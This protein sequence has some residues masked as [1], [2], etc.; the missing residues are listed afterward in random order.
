MTRMG[1]RT[2]SWARAQAQAIKAVRFEAEFA[3]TRTLSQ[4]STLLAQETLSTKCSCRSLSSSTFF[5]LPPP[6]SQLHHPHRHRHVASLTHPW[7][8]YI[9]TLHLRVCKVWPSSNRTGRID[10]N[11]L[12]LVPLPTTC[13]ITVLQR[14]FSESSLLKFI[15]RPTQT[16]TISSI[17]LYKTSKI[18]A[19]KP[20]T[21]HTCKKRTTLAH[22]RRSYPH[23]PPFYRSA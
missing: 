14:G 4:S 8:A 10:Q 3:Q 1:E 12:S 5:R 18:S 11:P 13:S 7:Q 16:L 19:Q 17:S 2:W 21:G 23:N 9:S 6:P 22:L 15:L 20:R